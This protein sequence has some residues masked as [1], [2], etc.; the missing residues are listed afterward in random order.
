M[1]QRV[2]VYTKGSRPLSPEISS[3]RRESSIPSMA[4][5]FFYKSYEKLPAVLPKIRKKKRKK[6]VLSVSA[7]L[8]CN[9]DIK[10]C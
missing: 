9:L 7:V 2:A 1:K 6:Q 4:G 5:W 8:N 10:N 3:S